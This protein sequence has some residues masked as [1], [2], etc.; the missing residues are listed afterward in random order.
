MSSFWF[1][2]CPLY[3]KL[4][5]MTLIKNT[6]NSLEYVEAPCI[7]KTGLG[8]KVKWA[9]GQSLDTL[10]AVGGSQLGPCSLQLCTL[11]L[12]DP[13]ILELKSIKAYSSLTLQAGSPHRVRE[14]DHTLLASDM[15]WV[16][17]QEQHTCIA[18][19]YNSPRRAVHRLTDYSRQGGITLL[20]VQNGEN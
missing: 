13:S 11:R 19:T 4:L 7:H 17:L 10:V 12:W 1:L 14:R 5:T 18:S 2:A 20:S 8:M 9:Q 15:V 16:A 6:L 3:E